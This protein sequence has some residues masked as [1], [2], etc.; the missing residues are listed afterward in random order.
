TAQRGMGLDWTTAKELI[1][2]SACA[3]KAVGGA[4]ASGAG[5]DHLDLAKSLTLDDVL[6]AYEEQCATVEAAGS[7]IILMASRA[8]A[9][10]AKTAEDYALVYGRILEQAKE[11]VILHWLGPMFDPALEGYWGSSDLET[12]MRACLRVIREHEDKVDGV[13]ISLLDADLEVA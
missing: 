9:R 8:L 2:R 10:I 12:A 3:A 5:T 1:A 6:H 7:R 13:K 11:P 4:I